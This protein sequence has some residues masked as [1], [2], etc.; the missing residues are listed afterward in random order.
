MSSAVSAPAERAA[1]RVRPRVGRIL[2]VG[3]S[4]T[5][6]CGVR[7]YARVLERAFQRGGGTDVSLLWCDTDASANMRA[8]LRQARDWLSRVRREIE[9]TPPHAIILHYSVF[10]YGPR[11]L[12][13]LA[14]LVARGLAATGIPVLGLLH[15]FAYP[16][17][18]RGCRGTG[19]ALS[20]RAVLPTVVRH[21]DALAVTTERR[22]FWL[23]TR[24]WLPRRPIVYVPVFS[25]LPLAGT[26][27]IPAKDFLSI[28]V[29]GFSGP[30]VDIELVADAVAILSARGRKF[31]LV[32]IGAPGPNGTAAK[33]WQQALDDR[34]SVSVLR[35][36][37]VQASYDLAQELAKVDVLLFPDRSGPD[38]RRTTL[39]AGLAQGRAVLAVD[40]PERWE[41]AVSE[42]AIIIAPHNSQAFA[43]ELERLLDDRAL[44]ES[45]GARAAEFYSRFMTPEIAADRLVEVLSTPAFTAHSPGLPKEAA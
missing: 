34:G 9:E 38:S 7:D 17:G 19:Q 15:E 39:A 1:Q 31:Q 35:F 2:Q 27:A 20:H 28:G 26:E 33:C 43:A 22:A 12:P 21:C 18:R 32:L 25:N 8:S 11:G 4:T 24:P 40:G 45:Q 29:F 5:P 10:A 36:T 37:G 42:R 14:P 16:F 6:V 23:A 13:V 44:R 41:R 3:I 30:G